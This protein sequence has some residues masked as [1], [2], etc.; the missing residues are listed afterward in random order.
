MSEI[1]VV[2]TTY[3]AEKYVAEAVKSVLNQTFDNFEF[4]IVDDGSI[5]DTRIIIQSFKDARIRF[6]ENGHDFIASLN[7]GIDHASGKYI[8]RM[9]ADDIMHYKRLETQYN[10][11]E[12]S[13]NITVCSSWMK[14]F[15]ENIFEDII[16]SSLLGIIECPLLY[17]LKENILF[18]PTVMIR[19]DFLRKYSLKYEKYEYA[20]DYKLWVEIAK[21]GGRFYIDSR[22]LL[23]YRINSRQISC[24]KKE[25]QKRTT[26][27][28]QREVLGY[29]IKKNKDKFRSLS[30]IVEGMALG[31]EENIMADNDI[32]FF[33][34]DV[35]IKNKRKLIY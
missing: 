3:N 1:S 35:F 17:L 25:E 16:V 5:D 14:V 13:L 32:L 29:L 9:D 11:M 34:H 24:Q 18:H 12:E 6:F 8:A 31:K 23:S 33:F 27:R 10:V 22:P 4:I 19:T 20:E 28:I 30:I 26:L 15:G 2:M 21:C 7:I